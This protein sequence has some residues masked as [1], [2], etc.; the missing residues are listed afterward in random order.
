LGGSCFPAISHS[1]TNR[2]SNWIGQE[3]GGIAP[4][5]CED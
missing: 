1:R 5:F 2:E 3:F 4:E